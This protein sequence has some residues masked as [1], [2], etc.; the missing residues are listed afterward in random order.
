[1]GHVPVSRQEDG[2]AD[3]NP[4]VFCNFYVKPKPEADFSAKC[5]LSKAYRCAIRNGTTY[6]QAVA[7]QMMPNKAERALVARRYFQENCM[8]VLLRR[9]SLNKQRFAG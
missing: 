7:A 1:M 3:V 4:S 5:E 2:K 8:V 9:D 6:R